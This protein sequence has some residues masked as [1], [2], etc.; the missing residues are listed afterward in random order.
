MSSITNEMFPNIPTLHG[1]GAFDLVRLDI[2]SSW[3]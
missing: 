2:V 1:Q 3:A